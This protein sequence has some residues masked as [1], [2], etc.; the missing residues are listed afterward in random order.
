MARK[1]IDITISDDNR[2]KG[3]VFHIK[4]MPASQ[5]EEW[6]FRALLIL[7]QA[8]VEVPEAATG[9]AGIAVAGLRSFG[10]L[11]FP[12][13]KLL[14]DEMFTCITRVPNSKQPTI[15]RPLVEDDTEEVMTRLRLRAEV[16]TLH[17]GFSMAELLS[18]ASSSATPSQ[19]SSQ[20]ETSPQT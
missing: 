4:E 15:I 6:A 7:T 3:K 16:F 2:D 11:P 18:K 1:E 10:G 20:Q 9:M 19:V 17:T 12:E 5:A 8:G 13:V 14:M